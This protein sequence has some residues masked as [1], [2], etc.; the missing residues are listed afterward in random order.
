MTELKYSVDPKIEALEAQV[1]ALKA[2]LNKARTDAADVETAKAKLATAEKDLAAAQAQV[3]PE[4]LDALVEE[5]ATVVAAAKPLSIETAGKSTLSIKRAIVAKK[6]PELATRVDALG[7]ETIDT[8]M[9]VYAALPHP[10][11]A[12]VVSVVADASR[13]DATASTDKVPTIAELQA[14]SDKA[15]QDAWKNK[16]DIVQV[17][18]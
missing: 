2:E 16:G 18:K 11:M 9:A 4:R 1:T 14:R 8:L 17:S 13:T 3:T 15:A 12:A 10:S 6:T 7:A 5:R